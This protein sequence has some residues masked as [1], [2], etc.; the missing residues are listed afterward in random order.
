MNSSPL[1]ILPGYTTAEIVVNLIDDDVDEDT[2]TAVLIMGSPTNAVKGN[3]FTH[4]LNI[5]DNDDPPEVSFLLPDQ[6]FPED[7]DNLALLR[8]SHPSS[9]PIFV[10]FD[11]G[12]IAQRGVDYTIL[13]SPIT[14]PAMDTTFPIVVDVFDDL[15]DEDDEPFSITLLSAVNATIGS[16]NVHIYTIL[17]ND[18]PP[19]VFFTWEEQIGDELA[20]TMTVE[21]QLT[22]ESS[23]DI[24]VPFNITGS[25][26]RDVDYTIDA[27]PVFIPA[28]DTTA[29]V[30]I[31][32]IPDADDE[33]GDET[34]V[35]M[36]QNPVNANRGTPFKHTVTITSDALEP[37]AYFAKAS[38]DSGDMVNG[39]LEVKVLLSAAWNEDVFVPFT[40]AG[41]ATKDLDYT[42]S[43]ESVVISRR[44]CQCQY[45][46]PVL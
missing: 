23:K 34:I 8:L 10:D 29:A 21:F 15:I 28:G 39:R 36:I 44:R 1:V 45:I 22:I 27:T 16:P 19:D 24:T 37:S 38:Q 31:T 42:V 26:T 20:G 3:P 32:V 17:D 33:E 13:T 30:L 40:F 9:K 14:I 7:V 25:A 11:T 41:T 46:Y 43:A 12:G 6:S 2:E 35:L 18:D 4:I 5:E